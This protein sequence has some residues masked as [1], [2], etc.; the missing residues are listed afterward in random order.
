MEEEKNWIDRRYR[1]LMECSTGFLREAV[2]GRVI[3]RDFLDPHHP[4]GRKGKFLL[5]VVWILKPFHKWIHNNA[6]KAM[7]IGWLQPKYRAAPYDPDYKRPWIA[8]A[9]DTWPEEIRRLKNSVQNT[10]TNPLDEV[11][12]NPPK[13][14]EGWTIPSAEVWDNSG[15]CSK[16]QQSNTMCPDLEKEIELVAKTV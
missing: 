7:E 12:Y 2:H 4:Y 11:D 3:H 14:D 16:E 13:T 15:H 10:L 1:C 5:C 8:D 9:E 6:N